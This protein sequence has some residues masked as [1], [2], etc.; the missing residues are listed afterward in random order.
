MLSLRRDLRGNGGRGMTESVGGF[1][2]SGR[3]TQDKLRV[4]KQPG[5]I[6]CQEIAR[7]PKNVIHHSPRRVISLTEHGSLTPRTETTDRID[8][9]ALRKFFSRPR[10]GCQ[11]R[12]GRA[13]SGTARRRSNATVSSSN[14]H[15]DHH[16]HRYRYRYYYC[17]VTSTVTVRGGT[18]T[19]TVTPRS[20]GGYN[21]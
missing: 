20:R 11:C 18:V 21:A 8:E 9:A 3:E 19:S 17:N 13:V 12:R 10:P 7:R 14:H 4:K 16:R 1:K 5:G 15:H 2:T 6:P